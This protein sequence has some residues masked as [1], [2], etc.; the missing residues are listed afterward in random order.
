MAKLVDVPDLG[1]GAARRVGSSP[2]IRTFNLMQ[3]FSRI[4]WGLFFQPFNLAGSSWLP[5]LNITLDKN[6][7][8]LTGLLTVNRSQALVDDSAF[9][10]A[11]IPHHSIAINNA[12]KAD[13]SDPRVLRLA[14]QI[15]T[16]QVREIEE[17]RL[18]I[19]ELE[20]SGERGTE[21]LPAGPATLTS[22]MADE[23]REVLK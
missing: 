3:A 10:R 16:S 20:I 15:I 19:M 13:I 11:M 12:R 9:L 21:P 1:S 23:A 5:V 2:S 18:L 6:D 14:D 4:G 22:E 7:E 17:M 8:Q